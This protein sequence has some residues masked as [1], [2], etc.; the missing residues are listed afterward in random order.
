MKLSISTGNIKMGLIPSISLPPVITCKHC[1]TC[2]KQCYALR[3][4]KRYKSV[5]NAYDRN[6]ELLNTNRDSYFLQVKAAAMLSRYFRFHVSGDIIDIDY[7]DRMV[8]VARE[9]KGTEFLCFTKNYEDVNEYFETHRKPKNLHLI[10]SLPFDG[11]KIE[12]KH[13]LPTAAVIFKGQDVPKNYKMC[14]GNCTECA[15]TC[16]GCWTL[17][18]G[19]TIAFNKH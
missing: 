10:F 12:N 4:C 3:M 16:G 18:N 19:E 5:K 11:S 1:E 8:K 13:N 14:G 9:L 2:A 7:L 15:N 17:K 6:L